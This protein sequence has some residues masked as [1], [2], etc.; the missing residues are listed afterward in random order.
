MRILM[1]SIGVLPYVGFVAIDVW[2]HEKARRVPRVEQWL[3]LGIGVANGSFLLLAFLGKPWPALA[4]LGL[5]LTFMAVDELGFHRG[6]STR[7]RRLHGAAAL[8][9]MLF[10]T[11]WLWTVFQH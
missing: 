1:L 4:M 5:G 3:H 10:V 9:L 11:L 2:M 8:S 6:L 7:E